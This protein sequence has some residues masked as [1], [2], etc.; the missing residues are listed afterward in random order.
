MDG[1][2]GPSPLARTD[3]Y[4]KLIKS[5]YKVCHPGSDILRVIFCGR[6]NPDR[7]PQVGDEHWSW[8]TL[9]SVFTMSTH[10]NN[11]P[12][13]TP[14]SHRS[15]HG[16]RLRL[17]S[18]RLIGFRRRSTDVHWPTVLSSRE[19]EVVLL[20]ARGLSNKEVARELGLGERT[21]KAHVH[22][23]LQNLGQLLRD[24]A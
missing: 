14:P 2:R 15:V 11:L 24:R 1:H 16:A 18:R 7:P 17:I 6:T 22:S 10:D 13:R 23:I 12:A 5:D 20:V 4:L 19:R 21:V 3:H 8:G 9:L